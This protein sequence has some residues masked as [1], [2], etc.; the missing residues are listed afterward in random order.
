MKPVSRTVD[1]ALVDHVN[2]NHCSVPTDGAAA[3]TLG[4]IEAERGLCFV[5]YAGRKWIEADMIA[6][7]AWPLEGRT[8]PA[9]GGAACASTQFIA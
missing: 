2:Q 7:P 9:A 3:T 4:S 1:A 5:G 6:G 8:F